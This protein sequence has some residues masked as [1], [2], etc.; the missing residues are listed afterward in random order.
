MLGDP[1]QAFSDMMCI[2]RRASE[3]RKTL[4][5]Q[6]MVYKNLRELEK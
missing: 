2:E 5:G 1:N 3:D 6:S 4:T